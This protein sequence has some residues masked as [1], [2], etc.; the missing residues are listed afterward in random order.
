MAPLLDQRVV[1]VAS[2]PVSLPWKR[3]VPIVLPARAWTRLGRHDQ[4]CN[5]HRHSE[6]QADKGPDRAGQGRAGQGRAE[7]RAP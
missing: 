6:E 4:A 3:I 7:G 2:T 1:Q 5:R